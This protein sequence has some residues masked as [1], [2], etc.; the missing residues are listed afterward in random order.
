MQQ[1][2]RACPADETIAEYVGGQLDVGAMAAL[3]DHIGACDACRDLVGEMAKLSQDETSRTR[4]TNRRAGKVR[5]LVVDGATYTVVREIA[6]G[7]MGRILE[8]WDDVHQRTVALKVSLREDEA[9][10]WR[11]ERE[12]AVTAR[13]SH[14]SI[15]PLYSAGRW[16]DGAPF[17]A[18]KYVEGRSFAELAAETKTTDAKLAQLPHLVAAIE[19]LAYAHERG[20]VHRDIKPANVLVGAFGE[21]MVI[22][23][24]LAKQVDEPEAGGDSLDGVAHETAAGSAVGTPSFM[25]PE[26]ARGEPVDAR[27]D[28]YA[29]GA[30]LY[31]LLAGVPPHAAPSARK[32]LEKVL[33]GPPVPLRERAPDTPSDLV[34]IVEKAM[35]REP[36]A[37]YATAGRLAEDLRRFMTGQLVSAHVYSLGVLLRRWASKHK[38]ALSVAASA[39]L[40][41]AVLSTI[42][43]RRVVRERDRADA[44]RAVAEREQHVALVQRD[45]AEQ[46]VAWMISTLRTRLET[47][48]R[49]DLLR[50]IGEEVDKYYEKA[51]D[52]ET[53]DAPALVRRSLALQSLASVATSQLDGEGAAPLFASAERVLERALQLAPNDLEAEVELVHV[54]VSQAGALMDK[55]NN[56]EAIERAERA[57]DVGREAMAAH[58]NEPR[59]MAALAR[60]ELRQA[61][62]LRHA[63]R[64]GELGT[65]YPD[66]C[67]LLDRAT[68][69]APDD[70]ELLRQAGWAY[71]ERGSEAMKRGA[72]AEAAPSLE[73][74]VA[75]REHL[76]SLDPGPSR[77]RE[78]AW[79]LQLL[80]SVR[81]LLGAADAALA[82]YRRIISLRE[83]LAASD[84]ANPSLERDVGLGFHALATAESSLGRSKE[85]RE[86]NARALAIFDALAAKTPDL[87]ATR[88]DLLVM[89]VSLG[90]DELVVH[91]YPAALAHLLRARDVLAGLPPPLSPD[92]TFSADLLGVH[93]AHAHLG[94]GD[95]A[96]ARADA[97]RAVARME[98]RTTA[99]PNEYIAWMSLGGAEGALGDV[100][101]TR[102]DTAAEVRAFRAERDAF[103]RAQ[104]FGTEP[105][106]D[107]VRTAVAT[108]Q[109]AT[110]LG[111]TPGGAAEARALYAGMIEALG[112][113]E[114]Q[115]TPEGK[116]LLAKARGVV[117]R[118]G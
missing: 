5:L 33:A 46:L 85:A 23:W 99:S 17:F 57:V 70:T 26:Q 15:I 58:P 39:A 81:T 87:V 37:R 92:G 63:G 115:I 31:H 110:A 80:A 48:G 73:R 90:A 29:L 101:T 6:R 97:E 117:A 96:A 38:S 44:A 91:D 82:D 28:V 104:G 108:D 55:G 112:P 51:S 88:D 41:V 42:A 67:D 71:F 16:T 100:E 4:R 107:A 20:V 13:L 34:T 60:G 11:F 30:L 21:T 95:A 83:E 45:A 52:I 69:A 2:A 64:A 47:L 68:A 19:A 43:V 111:R 116:E 105:A 40:V 66:A 113:I 24:G 78:L 50:G 74:S 72:S 22:D 94:V 102:R 77:Q 76:V 1:P 10:R 106:G 103:L 35:A 8:A 12:I 56:D 84:P 59:A 18:M 27:A 62:V 7:G 61:L 75:I 118:G 14:P 93:L 79:S 109:L 89:L 36:A 49:L 114:G 98:E 32:A 54:R 25:P 65:L 9:A 53:L 86:H 3:E